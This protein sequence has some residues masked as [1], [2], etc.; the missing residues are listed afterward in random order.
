MKTLFKVLSLTIR[1]HGNKSAWQNGNIFLF[2]HFARFEALIP[3]YLIYEKTKLYSRSIASKELFTDNIFGRYLSELGGIPNNADSLMYHVSKDILQQQKLVAFPEGGIV[4]DRRMLDEKGR[5]R[6]YSRSHDERRKLHTGPAVIALAIAIFKQAVR[7]IKQNNNDKLLLQWANELGFDS[8]QTLLRVC[9]TPT[10]IIPCNITFYPLRISGNALKDSVQ[11]FVDNLH[12]RLSE[13]LLIE[14]NFLLKDTDMD[15]HLGEPIIAEDYWTKIESSITA[16]FVKNSELSLNEIFNKVQNDTA[17]SS[18]LFRLNY[19]R[20]TNKIR[21]DYMH[22]IYSNVTVNIAHIAST[23]IMHFV[24]QGKQHVNKRKL[25]HLIYCTIKLL[26]KDESLNF[27]RTLK[28]PSIYRNL[29]MTKSETFNQF[30]RGV[31]KAKLLESQGVYYNFTYNLTSKTDFDSIRYKNPLV[32]Y[33]NEVASLPP[34]QSAIKT[35]LAFKFN[36]K[37]EKFAAM[38]FEDELLEYHW[39]LA[40]FQEKKH[41]EINQQQ[42]ISEHSALPY[43][44]KPDNHNGECVVLVH[45]LLSSPAELRQLGDKFYRLGYIVVGC[46]LKGHGTSPWDLHTRTWQDWQQSLRQSIKIAQCYTKLIHLVGF[47]SGSLLALMAACNKNLHIS[48]VTACSTPIIL[49]D[50]MVQLV[51][52]ADFTNKIIKKVSGFE[53]IM[54]FK[55][56]KPEH[57]HINYHHTPISA[58]NQLLLL[59][60]KTMLR[61][62]KIRCPTLLIQGNNDPVVDASSLSEISSRIPNELLTHHWVNSNRHGILYENTDQCQQKVI[63]FICQQSK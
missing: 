12:K 26:Q 32:V 51:K 18:Y 11:F 49:K 44:L 1:T 29:L 63:D 42:K 36:K 52:A 15:I 53:G 35:S 4:K 16:S 48:S 17:W 47:S 46:R 34:I 23:L 41:E 5:Y 19:Q 33:A 28:N 56:N 31:Y 10:I 61:I 13:E 22:A 27:H 3:Q 2:N 40:Q 30:L 39:D 59:I 8:T 21:D 57:P 25:H 38:R 20:N 14:G 54:P 50:P 43:L 62:K 6:I 9:E 24:D 58:I 37:L 60:K 55:E 7:Q 45:G